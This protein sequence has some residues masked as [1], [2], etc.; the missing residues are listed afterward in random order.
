MYGFCHTLLSWYEDHP[1]A[2]FHVAWDGNNAHQ[3]RQDINDSYKSD[4]SQSLPE[5]GQLSILRRFLMSLGVS[6]HIHPDH[7]ADDIIASL[8]DEYHASPVMI[9]SH[10]RDFLQLV[11]YTTVL[12]TPDKETIWDRDKVMDEYGVPPKWMASFR[13]MDGDT[14]DNLAGLPYFRRKVISN[15]LDCYDGCLESILDD[16]GREMD[17]TDKERDKLS[18]YRDKVLENR[19]LMKLDPVHSYRSIEGESSPDKVS[20]FC[21]TYE[22]DSLRDDLLEMAER[23][24]GFYKTGSYETNHEEE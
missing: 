20:L 15:L 14:S 4:R 3:K 24:N 10:D 2:S 22:F 7:E 16:T 17:L 13:A 8:C 9:V 18:T 5:D 6:Q 21:D 11:N 12:A 19:R 23:A 1:M